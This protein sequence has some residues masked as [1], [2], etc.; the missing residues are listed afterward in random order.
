MDIYYEIAYQSLCI[1][2]QHIHGCPLLGW[3]RVYYLLLDRLLPDQNQIVS[4][5]NPEE[6]KNNNNK[7]HHSIQLNNWESNQAFTI[8]NTDACLQS[9]AVCL[10]L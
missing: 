3:K 9:R 7:N 2:A 4:Q 6:Q 5:Y 8:S 1:P 10:K